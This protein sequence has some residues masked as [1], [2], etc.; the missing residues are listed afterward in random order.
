MVHVPDKNKRSDFQQALQHAENDALF[1]EQVGAMTAAGVFAGGMHAIQRSI[2]NAATQIGEVAEEAVPL[3]V[4][5]DTIGVQQALM[6]NAGMDDDW[7]D[8]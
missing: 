6:A 3:L 8:I 4:P 7:E 2:V 5:A 1:L